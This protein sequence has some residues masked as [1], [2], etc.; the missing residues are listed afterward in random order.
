VS[1]SQGRGCGGALFSQGSGGAAFTQVGGAGGAAFSQ[2]GGGGGG[3]FSQG[4]AD[5]GAAF[6]QGVGG[7][8]GAA[9]SQGGD[10][11]GAAFYQGGGSLPLLHSQSQISQASLDENLLSPRH[12]PPRAIR[13][14]IHLSLLSLLVTEGRFLKKKNYR[15]HIVCLLPN[16]DIHLS[17]HW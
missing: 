17:L 1:F 3:S 8:G 4:G 15:V 9:F 5:G 10:G 13:Y 6:S 11:G 7:G 2:I 16:C 14:R 12:P